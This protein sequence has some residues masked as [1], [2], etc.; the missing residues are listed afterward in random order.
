MSSWL[1]GYR[2]SPKGAPSFFNLPRKFSNVVSLALHNYGLFGLIIRNFY[3]NFLLSVIPCLDWLDMIPSWFSSY[4]NQQ[5][6]YSHVQAECDK[7]LVHH[8]WEANEKLICKWGFLGRKLWWELVSSP[9]IT[10]KKLDV[11]CERSQE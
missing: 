8:K 11:L 10:F 2:E 7:F 3:G 9:A 4:Q 5:L 6:S 1:D